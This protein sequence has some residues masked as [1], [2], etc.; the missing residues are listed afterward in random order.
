MS[1]MKKVNTKI[2]NIEISYEESASF[3]KFLENLKNIRRTNGLVP[4]TLPVDSK[5]SVKCSIRKF[6][7]NPKSS[8]MWCHYCDKNSNN[9]DD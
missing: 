1:G 5:K 4:D 7:K 6:S 8:S 9:T 3:F 2:G